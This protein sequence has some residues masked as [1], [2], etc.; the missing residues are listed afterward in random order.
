MLQTEQPPLASS[1]NA[2]PLYCSATSQAL[3]Q[4]PGY[5][6]H[7]AAQVHLQTVQ[8]HTET[9]VYTAHIHTNMSM[10]TRINTSKRIT[11]S[12][13]ATLFLLFA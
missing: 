6:L 9:H 10:H 3:I 8:L 13:I 1:S 5:G 12:Q 11:K 7:T 4:L 2:W